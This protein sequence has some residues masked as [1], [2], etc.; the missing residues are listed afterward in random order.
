MKEQRSWSCVHEPKRF[1]ASIRFKETTML[2][3]A[4]IFFILA[5]VAGY[6]GFIGL[7]GLAASIAKILF[8]IFLVL[9]VISF[10]SRALRGG[11][12]L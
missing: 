1:S 6:F 5:L 11:S 3:W 12:V 2:G 8:L 7:A 4:L 9:L 10:V